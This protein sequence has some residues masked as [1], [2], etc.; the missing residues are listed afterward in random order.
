MLTHGSDMGFQSLQE[1][2]D[3]RNAIRRGSNDKG[4]VRRKH[5]SLRASNAYRFFSQIVRHMGEMDQ[6]WVC[7]AKASLNCLTLIGSLC[8]S[9]LSARAAD[10]ATSGQL[11]IHPEFC[12]TRC[13]TTIL[14]GPILRQS[15]AL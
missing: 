14:A 13:L 12:A 7:V 3:D 11:A 9:E 10:N 2:G 6:P 4:K 5:D 8:K 15:E 1:I